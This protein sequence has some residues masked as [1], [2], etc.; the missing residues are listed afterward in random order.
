MFRRAVIWCEAWPRR[1]REWEREGWEAAEVFR[2]LE[3]GLERVFIRRARSLVRGRAAAIYNYEVLK[4][5]L[6]V[7][8]EGGEEG[9]RQDSRRERVN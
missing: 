2:D 4:V 3:R 1:L 8:L 5:P 9:G 7:P 6:K